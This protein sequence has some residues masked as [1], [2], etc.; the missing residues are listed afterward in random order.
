MVFIEFYPIDDLGIIPVAGS[1]DSLNGAFSIN[2]F[3]WDLPCCRYIWSIGRGLGS[4]EYGTGRPL[5]SLPIMFWNWDFIR[6]ALIL[7]VVS[8]SKDWIPLSLGDFFCL[9][10]EKCFSEDY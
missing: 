2:E 10:T 4:L 9:G 1:V 8:S 3:P 5:I 6:L 7:C